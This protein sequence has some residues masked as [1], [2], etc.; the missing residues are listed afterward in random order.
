MTKIT[1]SHSAK[2][3]HS[4]VNLQCIHAAYSR[5]PSGTV[6][7]LTTSNGSSRDLF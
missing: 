5:L 6:L 4:G 7:I 1:L 2:W 3:G